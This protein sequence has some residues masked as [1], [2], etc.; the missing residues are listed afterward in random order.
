MDETH[1]RWFTRATW[2]KLLEEG[3]FEIEIDDVAESLLPKE[4]QLRNA[5]G[6][7]AAL[8]KLKKFSEMAFP[9]LVAIVFLFCCKIR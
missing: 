5:L 7:G 2:R 6:G 4:Y 8:E 9:D 3:G 1:L